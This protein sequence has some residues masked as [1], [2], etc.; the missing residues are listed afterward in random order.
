[1]RSSSW[2]FGTPGFDILG[3]TMPPPPQNKKRIFFNILDL[4]FN[5][6]YQ[7]VSLLEGVPIRQVYWYEWEY[8]LEAS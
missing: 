5:S 6:S 1:M 3:P 4:K 2:N 8:S 7:I